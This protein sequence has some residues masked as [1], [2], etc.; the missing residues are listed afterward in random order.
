VR[1]LLLF[2]V[3]YSGFDAMRIV[4]W[5]YTVVLLAVVARLAQRPVPPPFEPVVWIAIL[6]LATLR[7]P[8][9]PVYGIFPVGWL[10]AVVL[11]ARWHDVPLRTALLCLGA[12]LVVVAPGQTLVP[13]PVQAMFSTIVQTG[14]AIAVTVLA[15]RVARAG[16]STTA[17][18]QRG[19]PE[20][21][22]VSAR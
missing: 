20:P 7:S 6:L 9:L 18:G 2:G 3:P 15:L 17:I 14:G 8:A 16:A 19:L 11:A 1:K 5:L 12:L 4:G 13:P 22:P 21:E 10:I